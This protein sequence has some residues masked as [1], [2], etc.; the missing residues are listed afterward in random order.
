VA[1]SMARRCGALLLCA[2]APNSLN[3]LAAPSVGIDSPN[4]RVHCLIA[5]A[6]GQ[7]AL[8]IRLG[9]A[10]VLETSPIHISVDGRRFT[11]DC[12]IGGVERSSIDETYPWRGVHSTAVNHCQTA[13]I[14]VKSGNGAPL[15]TLEVRVFDDGVAFRHIIL[16]ENAEQSRTPDEATT[17]VLPAGSTVW[18]HNIDGHYESVHKSSAV[19][20]VEPGEWAA[21]PMTFRLANGAGYASITEAAL[22]NYSGMALQAARDRKFTLALA[23]N[24][25]A[26]YPF[27]LRYKNDVER[28]TQPATVRGTI[29]SPW[30]VVLVAEDLNGLVNADVI[31]NVCPPPDA[32][33]FPDGMNTS[34]IKPGRAVWK[35]LDGGENSIEEVKNFS[36]LARE[37]GFEY[38]V[39]EGFW[40]RWSD[41][42]VHDVVAY[43]RSQGVGLWFWRHSRDLR[44]PEAR[45]EFFTK[46]Q[47][48]GVVGAK[49]DFFDHEHK[50]LVDLYAALLEE[51]AR[52]QI[53]INFHGANKPTG[54]ARTWPNE[55]TR[56]AIKGMEARKL[57]NRARHDATLPFT[58]YLAGPGDYTPVVFGERRGDTT[59]A[60]QIAAAAAFDEPLLTYGANPKTLLAHAAVEMIKSIPP[61]WD[62]TIVLPMSEIG[63]L[64]VM[65]RRR[66]D[67]WFVAALNGGAARTIT[68]PADFLGEGAYIAMF[69][70]D[71]PSDATQ[72]E[73]QQTA[74]QRGDKLDLPLA[75][76]GGFLGRFTPA[77]S[78][79][80]ENANGD[81]NR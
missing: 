35:Y 27:R 66:G 71:V 62:E 21:P 44:T 24:H 19:E 68:V 75:A 74:A 79:P 53:M 59:A 72:V 78:A 37:L 23:H 14:N 67:K 36:Q 5:D 11:D 46:L 65:A 32:T 18:R 20:A 52:H 31:H 9:D 63:E 17:F 76:G 57:E 16:A 42:Q 39:V 25:P 7:L 3:C 30:R 48:W 41:A 60:H 4:E 51:A 69:V 34:W 80:S 58:R 47:D 55:L 28:L 10:N 22:V 73:I 43:S 64:A 45:T 13:T 70:R 56:E 8:S 2:S 54:E 49:I 26:S 61:V 1:T 40:R 15:L 6:D 77:S 38:Q 50:E 12:Q 33:L 29:T 81:N